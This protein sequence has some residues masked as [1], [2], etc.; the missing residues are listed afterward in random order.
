MAEYPQPGEGIT[1]INLGGDNLVALDDAALAVRNQLRTMAELLRDVTLV[2]DPAP[3]V[4]RVY[5]RIT[6]PVPGDYVTETSTM[7]QKDKP[8]WFHGTGYLIGHRDE[9]ACTDEEWADEKA[10]ACL[11]HEAFL[12]GPNSRPGDADEPFDPEEYLGDRRTDHAW[13]VQYGPEPADVARWVNCAFLVIP[14]SGVPRHFRSG[15]VFTRESLTADLADSGF[16]LK[17]I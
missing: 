5:S 9:W 6:R 4:R 2:G 14:V 3:F 1:G 13:Y 10:K 11:D 8:D 15:P 7:H 17:G 16:R 12:K